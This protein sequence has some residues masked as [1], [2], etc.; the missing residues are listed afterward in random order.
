MTTARKLIG[1][2]L[3]ANPLNPKDGLDHSVI[4]LAS[5]RSG[6]GMGLTCGI[7]LNNHGSSMPLR[8]I[9][10]QFDLPY[11]GEEIVRYGGDITP[12]KIH[13][14]HSLDWRGLTTTELAPGIGVTNDISILAAI[15]RGEG[16]E[17]YRACAGFWSWSDQDLESQLDI[18][19][20]T[21]HKWEL[22]PAN[23]QTVFD[24]DLLDQWHRCVEVSAR[25]QVNRWFSLFQG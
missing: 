23:Q 13:M 17:H 22:A 7:Q 25:E 10:N 4:L 21:L 14:V 11:D 5:N 9:F 20:K 19:S 16:P 8:L 15:S 18:K 24:Y 1:Q 3:V 2:L 12:D 6:P